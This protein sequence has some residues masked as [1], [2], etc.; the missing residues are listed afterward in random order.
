MGEPILDIQRRERDSVVILDLSG[1]LTIGGGD[2][3]IRET[4][5]EVADQ[6]HRKV[7]LNLDGLRFLDSS[8]LG[9]LV[10]ASRMLEGQGGQ[11]RIV[12]ARGPVRNVFQ[13]TRLDRIFP[14]YRDEDAAI[15]SFP[16]Q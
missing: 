16:R 15:A 8:G 11:M 13:I 7:V 9:S 3:R 2:M 4:I 12:N 10:I 5:R 14:D 6:G 1:R